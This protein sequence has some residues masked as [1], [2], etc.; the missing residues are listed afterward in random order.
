[1]TENTDE[2]RATARARLR[3]SSRMFY[4]LAVAKLMLLAWLVRFLLDPSA[5]GAGPFT[6]SWALVAVVWYGASTLLCLAIGRAL[7]KRQIRARGIAYIYGAL[8]IVGVAGVFWMGP[9]A[10]IS[11]ILGLVAVTTL[12]IASELGAFED[13]AAGT[14]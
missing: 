5:A 13:V 14:G 10:I 8:Q 11:A 12:H 9:F 6:G 7:G 1:M 2:D 4:L 3:S